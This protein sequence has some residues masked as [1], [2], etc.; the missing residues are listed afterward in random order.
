LNSNPGV[1]ST[2]PLTITNNSTGLRE[3]S[4][5]DGVIIFPNPASER[6]T[7]EI[8]EDMPATSLRIVDVTGKPV[9]VVPKIQPGLN[10]ISI[11]KYSKGIYFLYLTIDEKT[12]VHKLIK[13]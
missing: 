11:N 6:I 9:A 1:S 7:I 13:D 5:A 10:S 12:A 2:F 4:G 3:E 8:P